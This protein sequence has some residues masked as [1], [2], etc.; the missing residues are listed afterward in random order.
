MNWDAI[1]AIG[2]VVGAMAV[3]LTLIYL[4]LQIRRSTLESQMAAAHALT[5]QLNQILQL[6]FIRCP[7]TLKSVW[8]AVA[9]RTIIRL[10][11]RPAPIVPVGC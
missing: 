10:L 4:A 9:T 5:N 11:V 1:S 3:I 7:D 6:A 2:E 8:S